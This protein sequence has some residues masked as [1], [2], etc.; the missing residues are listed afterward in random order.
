MRE[1]R[2]AGEP[3]VDKGFRLSQFL[4]VAIIMTVYVAVMAGCSVL[5]ETS[6]TNVRQ[7][8]FDTHHLTKV[9]SAFNQLAV[10]L[11]FFPILVGVVASSFAA[12]K[13]R[14]LALKRVSWMWGP[15]T[16]LAV[17]TYFLRVGFWAISL[18]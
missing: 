10:L 15:P 6:T 9:S 5:V 17:L 11:F 4:Y 1:S 3:S 8:T 12:P 2:T 13:D 18:G 14:L 7:P 16:I